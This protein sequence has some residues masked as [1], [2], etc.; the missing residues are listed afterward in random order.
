MRN[1]TLLFDPQTVELEPEPINPDWI[2]RGAPTARS[3]KLVTTE[4]ARLP[5]YQSG[6]RI[7]DGS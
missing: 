3:N 5:R 4:D 6:A 2:V 7:K 1:S